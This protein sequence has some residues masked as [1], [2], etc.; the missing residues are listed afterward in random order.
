[1]NNSSL[2]YAFR[3]Y[4]NG[5]T[6]MSKLQFKCAFV[7][8]TGMKPSK[9]DMQVVTSYMESTLPPGQRRPFNMEWKEFEKVMGIY[10]QQIEQG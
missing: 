5:S 7:Y 4:S 2:D 3:K 9:Q 1:M 8:V 6:S 10:I